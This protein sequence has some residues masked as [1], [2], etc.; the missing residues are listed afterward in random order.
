MPPKKKPTA[1][2]AAASLVGDVTLTA[3]SATKALVIVA[4]ASASNAAGPLGPLASLEKAST[5]TVFASIRVF[6]S[7]SGTLPQAH[8]AASAPNACPAGVSISTALPLRVEWLIVAVDPSARNTPPVT[9][10][11]LSVAPVCSGYGVG[12]EFARLTVLESME[13]RLTLSAPPP[14]T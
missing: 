4:F 12:I 11:S 14:S 7:V 9:A 1:P 3:L 6:W 8:S 13:L 10:F 2:S 5:V